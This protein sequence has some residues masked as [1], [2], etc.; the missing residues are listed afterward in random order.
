MQSTIREIK[1]KFRLF[2][3][4]VI[5]QSLREKGLQYRLIFGIGSAGDTFGAVDD[6]TATYCE[7]KVDMVLTH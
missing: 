1:S 5:S 4:G 7:N 2:M 3:N 6:G